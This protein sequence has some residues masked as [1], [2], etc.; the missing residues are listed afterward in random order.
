MSKA[1]KCVSFYLFVCTAVI[2]GA[3]LLSH[4]SSTFSLPVGAPYLGKTFVIDAGHGGEDGGA[5]SASGI[6]ESHLNLQI[7]HRLNDLLHFLGANTRMVRSEDVSVHTQGNTIAQRKVSDIRER[8][9]L[10]Q[11][12]PN[13]IL[14]SIHQN[15]FPQSKYRGAQVFYAKGS[16]ELAQS[17]QRTIAEQVDT[18][19]HRQCKSAKDIYLMEHISCPA[20]LVECGFLSNPSEELLLRDG[21]Y[22]KKIAVAI[23]CG[24]LAYTEETNEV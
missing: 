15:H 19:N 10:V 6:Y 22:Q 5:V 4:F 13:A 11:E 20:A 14:L 12:T 8:V 16:E 1:Q 18:N 21:S 17:I 7:A 24:V 23:A 3:L 9:R 2:T